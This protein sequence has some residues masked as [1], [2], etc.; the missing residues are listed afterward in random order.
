MKT[1]ICTKCGVEKDIEEFYNRNDSKN[2]KRPVCKECTKINGYKYREEN[3]E[4]EKF[5]CKQYRDAHKNESKQYYE[6][7]REAANLRSKQYYKDNKIEMNICS[8]QYH[9]NNKEKLKL[10]AKQYYKN[11]PEVIRKNR[12]KTNAKRKGW[13]S[14]QSI[15][16]WFE[17]SHLHHLHLNENHRI[18]IY[19]PAD[20]HKSVWHTYNR[21]ETMAIIN[22]LAF[23]WLATQDIII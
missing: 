3:K 7:N 21:S 11:H 12:N 9:K 16:N 19:I 13:L 4:K 5:R 18:A 10:S 8:K 2:G 1:K 15:N 6:D 14:P 20:L 17:N 23:E 22:M